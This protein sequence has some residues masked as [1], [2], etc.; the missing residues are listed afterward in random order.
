MV[1]QSNSSPRSY[2]TI[3]TSNHHTPSPQS[4]EKNVPPFPPMLPGAPSFP[5]PTLQHDQM[6]SPSLRPPILMSPAGDTKTRSPNLHLSTPPSPP[7][8]TSSVQPAAVPFQT[9]SVTPQPVPFSSSASLPIFAPP[10]FSNVSEDLQHQV[11]QGIEESTVEGSPCVLFSAH[12]V[13]KQRK[14]SNIPSLGFRALFSPGREISTSPQIVQR[15]PHRY[16]NCGVYSN[17]YCKILLG[18][19]QWY[20]DEYISLSNEDLRNFPKLSSPM[21]SLHAFVDVLPPIARI[22]IILYRFIVSI[23]DFSEQSMASV[24]VLSGDKSPSQDSLKVYMELGST[25][26]LCMHQRKYWTYKIRDRCLGTTVKVLETIQGPSVEMSHG[27]VKKVGVYSRIIVCAGGPNTYG[28]GSVP[29]SLT[30]PNYLHLEKMTLKWIGTCPVHV[31]VLQH[32]A[33]AYGAFGVNLQGAY[34]RASGSHVMGPSEEAHVESQENFKNGTSLSIQMLSVYQADILRVI[35]GRLPTVENE[36]II[37]LIAKRAVLRAKNSSDA[38]DMRAVIDERIK[39]I[40]L[41]FGS[42]VPKSKLHRFPKELSMLPEILFHLRQGPL[43]GNIVGHEDERSVLRN[44]FLNV[45]F[46]LSLR[47]VA[48]CCLMHREGGTFEELP[49]YK[50]TMQ[51]DTAIVLVYGNDVFIWLGV[52]LAVDEGRSVVALA[53]C[54]TFA[55]ELTKLRFPAPRILAFKEGSSQLRSLAPEQRTRLKSSFLHFDD[56]SF[57]EWVRSLKVVPPEPS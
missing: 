54:R 55:E 36:V 29:H 42:Q 43:L 50:L 25:F 34:S 19:G 52:E 26:H 48:P 35:T 51:F 47:M 11:P 2:I 4:E 37:I 30:H 28:P 9:S 12:K 3:G 53:T 46:D 38:V 27:V 20:K 45:S 44:L 8:F 39:D 23:Y 5:P 32:L 7:V 1:N 21:S 10:H 24:D 16:H 15:D 6:P 18:S 40:S 14:L 57:C 17:L 33:K 31:P 41:K 56:P 22:R 49:V 13:L